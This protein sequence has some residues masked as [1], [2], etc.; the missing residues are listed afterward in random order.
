MN[1]TQETLVWLGC[2]L[3]VWSG[4][5][6]IQLL[7]KEDRRSAIRRILYWLP[8]WILAAFVVMILAPV[9]AGAR[10]A[11]QRTT[12]RRAGRP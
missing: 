8:A 7:R 6:L 1:K 4:T 11:A 5:A 9:F 10:I 12:E 2:L 3:T